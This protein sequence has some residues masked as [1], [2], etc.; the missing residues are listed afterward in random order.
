VRSYERFDLDRVTWLG[1]KILIVF[2]S[3]EVTFVKSGG[4]NKFNGDCQISRSTVDAA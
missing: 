2:S 1:R 4:D 3:L